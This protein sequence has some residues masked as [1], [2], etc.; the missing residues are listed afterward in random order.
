MA[1]SQHDINI[2]AWVRAVNA[3]AQALD[4]NADL[5]GVASGE[6][7]RL[8]NGYVLLAQAGPEGME[9]LEELRRA[10]VTAEEAA[11]AL[12]VKSPKAICQVPSP[13]PKPTMCGD[14]RFFVVFQ[15]RRGGNRCARWKRAEVTRYTPA[16][17]EAETIEG[18]AR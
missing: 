3:T 6:H 15:G 4:H 8:M 7:A 13:I 10:G 16:C 2:E 11:T 12:G 5:E 1:M 18:G 9:R 14:C 17:E